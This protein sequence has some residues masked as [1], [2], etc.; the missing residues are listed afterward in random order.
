MEGDFELPELLAKIIPGFMAPVK[1]VN[2]VLKAAIT[3]H[4]G[5]K[6]Y[7]RLA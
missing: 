6:W 7:R 3:T 4:L 2:P 5:F 1:A